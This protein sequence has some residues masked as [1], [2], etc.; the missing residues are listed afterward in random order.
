MGSDIDSLLYD[1]SFMDKFVVGSALFFTLILG[2]I[3]MGTSLLEPERIDIKDVKFHE[4]QI[5]KVN[6]TV[7][8][9]Y[10]NGM[11][12]Y[13]DD[14]TGDVPVFAGFASNPD[15]RVR[16]GDIVEVVGEVQLYKGELEIICNSEDD[17]R[18]IYKRS[19]ETI[20]FD[21]LAINPEKYRDQF[22][23]LT[24]LEVSSTPNTSFNT[25]S[26]RVK[27]SSHNIY[28]KSD[29]GGVEIP[30]LL[31][32]DSVDIKG[33]FQFSEYWM[34]YEIVLESSEEGHGVWI[35]E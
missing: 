24:D 31:S 30:I 27:D 19:E 32:G 20:E 17:F 35:V 23:Y 25:T 3:A 21:D 14:G 9:S 33:I 28:V 16:K 34:S 11:I 12:F 13:L 2:I 22:V 26:F 6:G 15:Y 1:K 7:T 5:V 18:F 29:V 8:E 10:S 4:N